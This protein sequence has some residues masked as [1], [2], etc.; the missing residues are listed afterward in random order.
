MLAERWNGRAWAKLPSRKVPQQYLS[1]L[2]GVSCTSKTACIAV[3]DY[4]RGQGCDGSDATQCIE[5]AVAET[6][7]GRSWRLAPVP[8]PALAR[9]N[10][11]LSGV[12]CTTTRFCIAVG[13][14]EYGSGCTNYYGQGP[15]SRQTMIV[16]WDGSRWRGL[17]TPSGV[18]S[19]S[20]VSCRS[21]RWCFAV[22]GHGCYE[23]LGAS[24]CSAADLAGVERW[25]GKRWTRAAAP[26]PAGGM[27]PHLEGVSCASRRVCTAVGDYFPAQSNT[28][29]PLA[30]G[31]NGTNWQ[32][33][34][35]PLDAERGQSSLL[36]VSCTSPRACT[37]VGGSPDQGTTLVLRWDGTRWTPEPSPNPLHT[38]TNHLTSISCTNARRCVAV[39]VS[40]SPD[41][42]ALAEIWNGRSW[43]IVRT[44]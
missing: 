28:V 25:D 6:W 38:E 23:V 37:A 14:Y 22:G 32:V 12:S 10:S 18:G 9:H 1:G 40:T 41:I 34:T 29:A 33:E 7:D 35:T 24:V 5:R 19:L 17:P 15:C 20:A 31:W 27:T 30:V 2:S 44:P 13:G 36:G 4:R 26:V 16:R 43:R 11:S 39:G 8:L 3:G 42:S 21:S